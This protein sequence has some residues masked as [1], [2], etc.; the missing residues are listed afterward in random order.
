MNCDSEEICRS[1]D[2]RTGRVGDNIP[3]A[4]G[5]APVSLLDLSCIHL[6]SVRTECGSFCR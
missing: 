2:E 4:H 3:H 1:T 5:L 6:R